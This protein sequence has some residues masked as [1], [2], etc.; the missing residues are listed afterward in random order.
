MSNS[1]VE[2]AQNGNFI[3]IDQ[4]ATLK[5][6][7]GLLNEYDSKRAENINLENIP[8]PYKDKIVMPVGNGKFVG[9]PDQL[10]Q[11]AVTQWL[12]INI[13]KQN[14]QN[15]QNQHIYNS[16]IQKNN[17]NNTNNVDNVDNEN[18]MKKDIDT[19]DEDDGIILHADNC[20]CK[21]CNNFKKGDDV[22]YYLKIVICILVII[23]LMYGA[24]LFGDQQFTKFK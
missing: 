18:K 11:F 2:F 20:K 16:E 7:Y 22:Y 14:Q 5:Y 9:I 23:A 15:K 13:N 10:Q 19:D 24:A 3:P 8:N 1:Q 6:V 17:V 21:K 4:E 12:Q